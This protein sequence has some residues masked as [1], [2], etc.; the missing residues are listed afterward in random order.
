[1]EAGGEALTAAGLARLA[2]TT[3][4][5]IGRMVDLGVLVQH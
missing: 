3:E 1:M 2:G 5:E 4:A